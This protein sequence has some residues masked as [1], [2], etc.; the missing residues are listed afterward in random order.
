MKKK[1]F[2]VLLILTLVLCFA[3]PVMAVDPPDPLEGTQ[4]IATGTSG[5]EARIIV[6]VP[7]GTTLGDIDS[8]AWSEYL[9]QG[10]PPHVDII[11]EGDAL[12]FEYAH[13][14]D[15]HY[16]EAPMPY[17]ALLGGWYQ[18]FSDDGEG[19]AAVTDT[20]FA[21]LSSGAAGPYPSGSGFI[22]GTLADWKAGSVDAGVNASTPVLR[23]EIEVDNWV[24]DSEAYVDDI[25][26]N[27]TGVGATTTVLEDVISISIVANPDP[28]NFGSLYPGDT[29]DTA[30]TITITNTGSVDITVTATT[31]SEFY[32]ASLILG[33]GAAADVAT[34]G[35]SDIIVEDGVVT[36]NPEIAVPLGWSA[37]IEAG[38]II[39]W[40]EA[41]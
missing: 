9:M 12:V 5:S 7:A 24:V 37:G 25:M 16:A 14:T 21:W 29:S 2:S 31:T 28:L 35:E 8:I 30:N 13:N 26:V 6:D 1:I 39:F 36:L 18:T 40:A 3:A 41:P 4:L 38:T 15:A 20:S 22:G 10:Y 34:W 32:D 23:L 27:G 19:P 17:G 33:G 11:I